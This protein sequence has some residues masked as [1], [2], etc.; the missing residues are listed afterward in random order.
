MDDYYIINYDDNVLIRYVNNILFY[1]IIIKYISNYLH[2]DN[3]II[4]NPSIN[5]N[6]I[7]INQI[8]D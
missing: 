3:I 5:I 6:F 8:S 1:L 7:K 2:I 4:F